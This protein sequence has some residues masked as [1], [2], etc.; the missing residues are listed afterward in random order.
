MVLAKR[1]RKCIVTAAPEIDASELQTIGDN[2]PYRKGT[3][4]LEANNWLGEIA[5]DFFDAIAKTG[6]LNRIQ[7]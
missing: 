1:F 3:T 2:R 7:I 6:S 5:F 4:L